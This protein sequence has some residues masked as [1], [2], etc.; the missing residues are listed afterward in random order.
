MSTVGEEIKEYLDNY[1]A[2]DNTTKN[3]RRTHALILYFKWRA[4]R[5]YIRAIDLEEDEYV[6]ICS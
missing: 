6:H 3:E 5:D 4:I 1:R 2:A